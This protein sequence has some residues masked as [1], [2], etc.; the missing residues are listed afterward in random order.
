MK[1][2][3]TLWFLSMAFV[4]SGCVRDM[5]PFEGGDGVRVNINGEKCVMLGTP[6]G[7]Y[8]KMEA[9]DDVSTF[10]SEI[11]L[12]STLI[13]PEAQYM[14]AMLG[15]GFAQDSQIRLNLA[16][17]ISDNNVFSK[18]K[19]YNIGSGNKKAVLTYVT[20]DTSTNPDINLKG[21]ISFLSLGKVIEARFELEGKSTGGKEYSLRHGFLRLHQ[22]GEKQ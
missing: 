17:D 11:I 13:D 21:W 4:L 18:E 7:Y 16:F 3:K 20:D 15:F 10:K 8:A 19:Q 12:I 5:D 14:N 9:T 2:V 22:G 6:G 1:I